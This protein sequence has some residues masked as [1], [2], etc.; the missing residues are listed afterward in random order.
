MEAARRHWTL[1]PDLAEVRRVRHEIS[2]FVVEQD[3]LPAG[4]LTDLDLAVTE[5][6]GNALVH[7]NR[8][9]IDQPVG[10]DV[11]VNGQVE[12]V[13]RDQGVGLSPHP[14]APGAGLGLDI[15]GTLADQLEL[16]TA[17]GGGTE[18]RIVFA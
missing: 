11:H 17:E 9:G 2:Q 3:G 5:T 1:R 4:R 6:V 14:E 13:V 12:I 7:G 8:D 15:V 10:V 16:R 18:V